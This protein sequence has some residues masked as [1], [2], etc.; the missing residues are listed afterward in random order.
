MIEYIYL[1]MKEPFQ[2]ILDT[3]I[4]GQTLSQGF[5]RI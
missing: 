1:V 5:L 2:V 3:A 4:F